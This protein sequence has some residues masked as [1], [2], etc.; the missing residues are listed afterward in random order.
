VRKF[1]LLLG[2]LL[3]STVS[4]ADWQTKVALDPTAGLNHYNVRA[5]D[6]FPMFSMSC[7]NVNASPLNMLHIDHLA[8]TPIKDVEKIEFRVDSRPITS[9][10]AIQNKIDVQYQ[11]HGSLATGIATI[12]LVP[13]TPTGQQLYQEIVD[14]F[15]AGTRAYA[16]ITT[17]EGDVE[18][19]FSLMGF[20]KA[21]RPMSEA[22]SANSEA[23]AA[24]GL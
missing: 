13:Q 8:S 6:T 4:Q 7:V 17:S 12:T 5:T 22:C 19:E 3:F 14:Q 15:I 16:L 18:L 24:S 10:D 23:V 2:L 11:Y 20:T 9:L 21:Y 1:T